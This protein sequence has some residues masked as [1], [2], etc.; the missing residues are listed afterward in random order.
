M[1]SSGLCAYGNGLSALILSGCNKVVESGQRNAIDRRRGRHI[2]DNSGLALGRIFQITI[3][4]Y[5]ASLFHEG[6]FSR[7]SHIDQKK[8]IVD[9][10]VEYQ[11]KM[12]QKRRL[13]RNYLTEPESRKRR[14]AERRR[15]K[16]W[17]KMEGG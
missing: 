7:I 1:R 11:P 8:R 14:N 4:L 16:I 5:E 12:I 3:R 17:F 10:L 6:D 9:G 13:V 15:M 2:Q